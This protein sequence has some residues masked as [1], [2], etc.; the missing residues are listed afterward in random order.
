MT[1]SRRVTNAGKTLRCG[2]TTGTCAAAA[3]RAATRML[4]SGRT[5]F[6]EE[7]VTPGG[8]LLKLD[9]L[10]AKLSPDG[11]VCA[12]KKDAGDDPD[13][14]DG[15]LVYARVRKIP[16][17]V[18]IDGGEGVGRVTKPGLDQNVGA[19]AINSVPRRMIAEGVREVCRAFGYGG[20]ISVLIFIPGGAELAK[21][22][23]NPRLG[24]ENGLSIIGT[25][26]IVE[27]M[28][29]RALVDTIRLELRQLAAAGR[30][31]VLLT[32]GNYGEVFARD[33]L[34]LSL[35]SHVSCSNFIG[36]ALDAALEH[37]FTKILLVGH[38]GKLVKLGIGMTNTHSANGDGRMETLC[39]CALR[40]GA[41]TP[42]LRAVLDC[43]SA[44]AA[45]SLL[46]EAGIL[47]DTMRVLGARI[48]DCLSRRIPPGAEAGYVC[49][50][51]AQGAA[52]ILVQSGNAEE[53]MNLWRKP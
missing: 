28:S 50:T 53:L 23:F 27:P 34:G 39:A 47:T 4:L 51:N 19:A 30:R 29:S 7:L 15:I 33:K 9:I 17:G 11:A 10:D 16:E 48:Q 1:V 32:P 52:G 25:T 8:A 18:A 44:D 38:I 35:S 21:R 3:A 45:I 13:V 40:A 31:A 49:F 14:T 12:V 20:G 24:I 22:T 46:S 6:S 26:G 37:G 42:L 5:V 2:Y 43:V 41:E 36:D